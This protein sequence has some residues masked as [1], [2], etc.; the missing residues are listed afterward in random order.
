MSGLKKVKSLPVATKKELVDFDCKHLSLR[1]QCSLIGI[2]RSGIYYEPTVDDGEDLILMKIMDQQYL[3]RLFY[4]IRKMVI[5][6]EEHG[7][8]VNRKRVVR[9]MHQMGIEAIYPKPNLS[10]SNPEHRK[11]PYLLRNVKIESP[12]QAWSADITYIPLEWWIWLSH[13]NHGLV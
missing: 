3:E 10:V 6:L 13:C 2:S 7:Y 8:C 12:N 11:Y 5:A 4:G 1:R 9:L